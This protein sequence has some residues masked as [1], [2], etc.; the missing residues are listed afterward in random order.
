MFFA[1]GLSK[2]NFFTAEVKVVILRIAYRPTASMIVEFGKGKDA[3]FCRC[4]R[5]NDVGFG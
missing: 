2:A 4:C 3:F 1:I 5:R